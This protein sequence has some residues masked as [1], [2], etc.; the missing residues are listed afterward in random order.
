MDLL[1]ELNR[2]F[3]S[4]TKNGVSGGPKMNEQK[5]RNPNAK[6]MKPGSGL[7]A[8]NQFT[9]IMDMQANLNANLTH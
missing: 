3:R 2:S 7:A 6:L 9:D 8:H 1:P 5:S 4:E